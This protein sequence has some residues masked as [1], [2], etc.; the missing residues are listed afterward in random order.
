MNKKYYININTEL[1]IYQIIE[2]C[3]NR[4]AIVWQTT[5]A[6]GNYKKYSFRTAMFSQFISP[7]LAEIARLK[8]FTWQKATLPSRVP[9]A[10]RQGAPGRR[11][12][13]SSM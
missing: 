4:L 3:Y 13:L 11:V 2:Y 10:S 9:W 5:L 1:N 6:N 7:R 12:T 8:P